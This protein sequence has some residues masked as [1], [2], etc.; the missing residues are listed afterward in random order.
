MESLTHHVSL[1]QRGEQAA[2]AWLHARYAGW[3]RAIALGS[4]SAAEAD[5]VV[6]SA[7]PSRGCAG[8]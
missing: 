2:F 4:L 5:D 1:A 7:A 8:A 3:V 6:L